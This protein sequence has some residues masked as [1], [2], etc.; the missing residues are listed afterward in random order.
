MSSSDAHHFLAVCDVLAAALNRLQQTSLLLPYIPQPSPFTLVDP[1]QVKFI[2]ENPPQSRMKTKKAKTAVKGFAIPRG[3]YSDRAEKLRRDYHEIT[4]LALG[5]HAEQLPGVKAMGLARDSLV[6]IASDELIDK[7]AGWLTCVCDPAFGH[8]RPRFGDECEV[9][10]RVHER[11]ASEQS[12]LTEY[13]SLRE[14]LLRC[15]AR[16]KIPASPDANNRESLI[17]ANWVSGVV[18][19]TQQE[20]MQRLEEAKPSPGSPEAPAQLSQQ[21]TK[22]GGT[23]PQTPDIPQDSLTSLIPPSAAL[24]PPPT[25]LRERLAIAHREVDLLR[26]LI[27]IAESIR[28]YAH[29]TSDQPDAAIETQSQGGQADG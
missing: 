12:K 9:T 28:P 5:M 10:S 21:C 18:H 16:A 26:R 14:E 11:F 22:Q 27:R 29:P 6:M 4:R 23:P 25:K 7:A 2:S 17:R 3:E 19:F 20:L 15:F 13:F 8:A 24:L 1:A